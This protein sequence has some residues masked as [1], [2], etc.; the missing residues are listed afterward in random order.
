[1]IR[2]ERYQYR[3]YQQVCDFL[4]ELNKESRYHSNWNWGR[5]EWMHE[6][7]LTK[8]ELLG[9]MGLWFEDDRL[10]GAALIDMFFGEAFVGVLRRYRALFPEILKYAYDNLKDDQGLGIAFHD[11]N[12]EEIQE[13]MKQGFLKAEGD[14]TDC[15][16]E[17]NK[18]YPVAVPNGFSI[19][20][21]DAQEHPLEMEWLC[22]QGFNNGNDKEEFLKQYEGPTGTRPHFNAYLCIVVKNEKHELVAT[23]STW[24][25]QKTDFAYV[26][27]VCVLPTYRKMGLGKAAVYAAIN[28]A[29]ELG[30]KTAIVNSGQDFYKRLG[31]KKKN[32][33]TF[34]WK[35]PL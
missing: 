13:A 11:D 19:E 5:F 21:F 14:E 6:H 23:A 35:K 15:E 32:H 24:Y 33:Y 18:E 9:Y 29:R 28:H 7:S 4:I 10:I 12:E 22:W 16:I 26:E 1:M 30:A 25:D 8:K 20:S 34:Y 17:L 27:P 2:F 3:Y 31:F